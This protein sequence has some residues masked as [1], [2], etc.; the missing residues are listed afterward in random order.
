MPEPLPGV[1]LQ[2]KAKLSLQRI[3]A[4]GRPDIYGKQ[5]V[6]AE[7][8]PDRESYLFGDVNVRRRPGQ[9]STLGHGQRTP[10]SSHSQG[11]QRQLSL[12]TILSEACHT[13]TLG[14]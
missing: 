8:E 11:W 5:G 12:A 4:R 6:V 7:S 1:C 9:R 13:H 3:H 2:G 14:R 10:T